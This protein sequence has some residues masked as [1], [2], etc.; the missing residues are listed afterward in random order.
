M[1]HHY[2][3]IYQT[4]EGEEPNEMIIEADNALEAT[5]QFSLEID[6]PIE[7]LYDFTMR[8]HHKSS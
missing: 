4:N 5:H 8:K 3:F 1:K 7:S 2:T 6:M